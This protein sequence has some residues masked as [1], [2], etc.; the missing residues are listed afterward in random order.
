MYNAASSRRESNQQKILYSVFLYGFVCL[1]S[2]I[3]IANIFNTISTGVALRKREFAMLRSVG[4]TTKQFNRMIRFE[5]LFYG[6]KG[7][8]YGLPLSIGVCYLI[9]TMFHLGIEFGFA[10]PWKAIAGSVLA[11]FVVVGITM[12]YATRKL[13]QDN[14]MEIL[15]QENI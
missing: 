13:K 11:V 1:I 2:M 14:I 9:Y 3:C 6:L 10:L 4:M 8:L 15:R 7:L 5:S 12:I